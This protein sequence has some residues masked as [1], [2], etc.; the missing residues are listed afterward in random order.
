MENHRILGAKPSAIRN[1]LVV[2]V[3]LATVVTAGYNF[4]FLVLSEDTQRRYK[5]LDFFLGLFINFPGASLLSSF[6]WKY[7]TGLWWLVDCCFVLVNALLGG[8]LGALAGWLVS[9]LV[10]F[11][12]HLF[13]HEY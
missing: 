5:E 7:G 6:G 13:L 2:G 10:N 12:K 11:C 1:G 4:S 8:A 9:A 3:V